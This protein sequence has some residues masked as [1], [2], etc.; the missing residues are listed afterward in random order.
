MK[1]KIQL[2]DILLGTEHQNISLYFS[3][4]ERAKTDIFRE[5]KITS[6]QFVSQRDS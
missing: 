2:N 5:I 6:F 3:Q 4:I 1:Y